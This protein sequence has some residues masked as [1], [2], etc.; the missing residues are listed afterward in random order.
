MFR[1]ILIGL[2]GVTFGSLA[3][4]QVPAKKSRWEVAE[5]TE[6]NR[7]Q[8]VRARILARVGGSGARSQAQAAVLLEPPVGPEATGGHL[9][10][11]SDGVLWCNKCGAYSEGRVQLLKAPCKGPNEAR[12]RLIDGGK[13]PATGRPFQSV[14]RR[15]RPRDLAR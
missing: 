2:I 4:A 15:A 8:A 5:P 12:V 1:S 6:M 14:T 10:F 11:V 13:H 9:L 3:V 7:L